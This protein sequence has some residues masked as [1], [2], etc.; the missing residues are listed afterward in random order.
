[1]NQQ[2]QNQNQNDDSM[3]DWE[4]EIAPDGEEWYDLTWTESE[5]LKLNVTNALEALWF[6]DKMIMIGIKYQQITRLHLVQWCQ[7]KTNYFNDVTLKQE[8]TSY[9]IKISLAYRWS[10]S[11]NNPRSIVL[12]GLP[13]NFLLDIISSPQVELPRKGG[14]EDQLLPIAS[15]IRCFPKIGH[16]DYLHPTGVVESWASW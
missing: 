3:E 6:L 14:V 13:K 12:D 9:Q 4:D 8:N 16:Y 5:A 2:N 10:K 15:P 11:S 1:M 7:V